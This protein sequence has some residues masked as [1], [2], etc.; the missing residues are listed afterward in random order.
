MLRNYLL[1]P[2]PAVTL[3]GVH[4]FPC[5]S[6]KKEWVWQEVCKLALFT[7]AERKSYEKKLMEQIKDDTASYRKCPGCNLLVQRVDPENL[8]VECLSCSNAKGKLY[9]F[10][11][12][13]MREWKSPASLSTDCGNKSCTTTAMLL[14]CPLIDAPHLEV[15]Q[16]PVVRACP[17][18]ET[19]VSHC[20]EGCPQVECPNCFYEFC[21]RCL[22]IEGC[23]YAE[24]VELSDDEDTDYEDLDDSSECIRAGRQKITGRKNYR[25]NPTHKLS[26]DETE[27]EEEGNN[28]QRF[29]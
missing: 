8:C 22:G 27:S 12:D 4:S 21:Y 11:W 5:Q 26:Q 24:F 19:L 3:Q 16:C 6:C 17:N 9:W 15:Y 29:I 20:Q 23:N 10:C 28:D 14:S 7:T 1:L 25:I 2:K 18:C 13:C